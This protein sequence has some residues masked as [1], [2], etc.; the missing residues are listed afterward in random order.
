MTFTIEYEIALPERE[1]H[2]DVMLVEAESESL[3]I[4]HAQH[5]LEEQYPGDEGFTLLMCQVKGGIER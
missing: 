3:A 4:E 2:Y 1:T 5:R